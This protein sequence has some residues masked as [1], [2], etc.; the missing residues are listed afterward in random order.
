MSL[1]MP[2]KLPLL[3]LQCQYYAK[4]E[5]GEEILLPLKPVIVLGLILGIGAQFY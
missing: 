3:S 5:I 1:L 2:S 4:I